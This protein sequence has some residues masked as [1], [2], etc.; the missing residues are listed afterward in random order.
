MS[1]QSVSKE[2]TT[3]EKIIAED[4][5]EIAELTEELIDL[6]EY[7]CSQRPVPLARQYRIKIDGE[8]YFVQFPTITGS[9]LLE[10]AHRD[11][12]LVF[13]VIQHFH[14]Q[15]T[16]V[17]DPSTEVDLRRPGV[18]KFTTEP[19]MVQ[20]TVDSQPKTVQAGSYVV[21]AFKTLVSVD[22][23]KALDQVIN[24]E[25]R[26][27]SDQQTV[28]ISGTEVFVSHARRGQSS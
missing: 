18:E 21:S 14:H 23:A 16:E 11:G 10:L 24:G 6:E 7:A 12:P 1:E 19:K 22:A 20:V 26:E 3:I 2:I 8:H 4:A 17:I 25:F 13:E 27:L 28:Q 9:K 15:Q 5:C